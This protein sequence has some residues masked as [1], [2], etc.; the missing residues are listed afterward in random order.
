M[1]INGI[2]NPATV[3]NESVLRSANE[4]PQLAGELISQ[5]VAGLMQIQNVQPPAQP[6]PVAEMT[7]TG[8]IINTMA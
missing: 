8:G 6:V 5:A 3:I 4:Q 2:S 1:Q 7:G